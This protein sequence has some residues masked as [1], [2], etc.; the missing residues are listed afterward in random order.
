MN[1]ILTFLAISATVLGSGMALPQARRLARTRR[2]EGVSATWVG[3]SVILNLWWLAYA[4]AERVYVLV[5]VSVISALLYAT[6]GIFV[7]RSTGRR[8]VFAMATGALG[9]GMVPLPFLLAGGWVLAGV[10]IGGCYG[11]QLAPAVVA[12]FRT[13][14]LVGVSS[15]T[16]LLAW[17]ESMLWLGYG[18]GIRDTALIAGGAVGAV[19]SAAILVR[20]AVTGHRPLEP[21]VRLLARALPG[22]RPVVV[23]VGQGRVG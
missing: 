13:R 16:W 5:P 7:V 2:V 10:A 9:L 8:S 21:V 4:L 6:I 1:L 12:T 14:V 23:E 17:L 22:R 3:V 11:L 19:M 20:L 18:V 15:F